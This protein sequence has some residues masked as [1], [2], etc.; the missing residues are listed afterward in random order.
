RW[1]VGAGIPRF[2]SDGAFA[3]YIGSCIDITER[4][5]AEAELRDSE[6]SLRPSH[7]QNQ[8][9]AGRLIT[10]QEVERAR[11][12]REL[13]DDVGQ[14]LASFSIPLG[15]HNQGAPRTP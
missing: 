2:A 8:E 4:Q 12:A 15:T 3:G 1:V 5:R 11:I 14:R 9:L 10:A 6:A 7:Q 13:H